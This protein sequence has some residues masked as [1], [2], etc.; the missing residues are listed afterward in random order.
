MALKVFLT[1]GLILKKG[2]NASGEVKEIKNITGAKREKTWH[3]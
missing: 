2:S 1:T 3:G